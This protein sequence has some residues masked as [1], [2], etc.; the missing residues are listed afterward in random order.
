[1]KK[2]R[3]LRSVWTDCRWEDVG[4][5]GQGRLL[6]LAGKGRLLELAG[7]DGITEMQSLL[8]LCDFTHI[9]YFS[10]VTKIDVSTSI[11]I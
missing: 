7:T 4:L 3:K 9:F 8:G 2:G 6:G 11:F 1:M 5:A 10:C